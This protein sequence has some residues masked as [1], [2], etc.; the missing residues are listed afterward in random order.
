MIQ[1]RGFILRLDLTLGEPHRA[2]DMKRPKKSVCLIGPESS[3]KSTL[4]A[5]L[6]ARFGCPLV[7]EYGR[8]Y[9]DEH[10]TKLSME[11]LVHIG[12][13][14]DSMITKALEGS[15]KWVVMDTDAVFTGIWAEMLHG[16]RDPWFDSVPLRSDF[17]LLMDVDLPFVQ[18]GGRVYDRIEDRR[19]FWHL[20]QSRFTA[21][22]APIAYVHGLADERLANAWTAID[23][24]FGGTA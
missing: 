24:H 13:T 2:T 9:C 7:P 12:H 11:Q 5:T 15:E 18:D 14:Q 4:A 10:G 20:C 23:A 8:S 22:G 17:Y 3:G 6:A 21:R 1:N 16:T 19:D